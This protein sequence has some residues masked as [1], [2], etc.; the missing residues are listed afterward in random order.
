MLTRP[1][2]STRST[3]ARSKATSF[4]VSRKMTA[5]TSLSSRLEVIARAIPPRMAIWREPPLP[6]PR[7]VGGWAVFLVSRALVY[8]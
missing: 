6:V 4:F 8:T 7:A 3:L 1:V 5:R 2:S